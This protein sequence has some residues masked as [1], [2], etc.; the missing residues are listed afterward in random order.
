MRRNS[1]TN[2][3]PPRTTTTITSASPPQEGQ[4]Q[5]QQ[6]EE[7]E[8]PVLARTDLPKDPL[9]SITISS[10]ASAGLTLSRPTTANSDPYASGSESDDKLGLTADNV[11]AAAAAANAVAASFLERDRALERE[12]GL[13]LSVG[14]PAS[15]TSS[16]RDHEFEGGM[17]Y[18]AY[19]SG[20][21][22][23]P[24]DETEQ[25]R[26]DMKHTVML[27]LC[28]GAYFYSPVREVLEKGG[29]VLDLGTG[30]GIWAMELG[31]MYPNAT[32]TGIDLSPIQPTYVPENVHFFVD[33][34]EE[35]WVDPEDKYDLI[36]IRQALHSVRDPKRLV[37]RAFRHL[38][39]GAYFEA[40][41]L[42]AFPEA[43][44]GS[45]TPDTP[46]AFR[47]YL[48][49]L[50]AGLQQFTGSQA[51]AV[52]NLPE[53]LKAAGFE[54]VCVTTHKCPIGVWPRDKRL[55]CCGLFLRASLMDGLKGLS[56]RPLTAIGWTPL[57]IEIFLVEV[58]KAIMNPDIHAYVRMHVVRGRKPMQ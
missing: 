23:F 19:H 28:R 3:K 20:R 37:E 42:N 15:V 58:R 27:M 5:Q 7:E 31:D 33:D 52:V 45:L 16:V 40:Q 10:A 22:A 26:D 21:Y 12:L 48:K 49:F 50:N 46:Y 44:D 57:Q 14:Y 24:N 56:W 54:D 25:N 4:Q 43:D 6:H 53:Q 41:E 35:E 17:R 11:A 47:D 32:F 30:T 29:E 51:H 2:N 8:G 18:H 13:D 36:H 55:R 38:K 34:F 39:P 9:P 1:G